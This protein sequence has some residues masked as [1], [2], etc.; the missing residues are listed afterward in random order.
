MTSRTRRESPA[1]GVHPCITDTSMPLLDLARETESRG[2]AAIYL[3][4]HTHIPVR[5]DGYP[6]GAPVPERYARVLDPFVGASWIA[7][8]TQLEVGTAVSLP[9]EHDPIALAKAVATLDFLSEGRVV[10]GVGFGWNRQEAEDHAMASGDRWA[11]AEESVRLMRNVWVH[12]EAEFSGRFLSLSLSRSWPKPQRPGGPPILIGGLASAR[13]F[14]RIVDWGDGW[15]PLGYDVLSDSAFPGHLAGLR[16][17][18]ERA[19]RDPATLEICAFFQ[20]AAAAQLSRT[21]DHAQQLGIGRIQVFLED[22]TAD[23]ALPILDEVA[24]AVAGRE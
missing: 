8:R 10:L 14:A 12:D 4:E 21:I 23:E 6:G 19:G 17:Q 16:Q 1:V 18:W 3:P 2:L 22:R 7:A 15:M 13:T 5:T 20:P 24:K 11:V 9:A